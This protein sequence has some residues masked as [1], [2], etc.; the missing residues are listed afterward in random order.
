[1]ERSFAEDVKQLGYGAGQVLRG[2]GILAIT[3]ALLQSGVSYVGGYPGAPISHLLDVLADANDSLLRPLGIYYEMSG[4]EAA[5]A[6]LLGA[7]INYP[8]RGAVTWKSVVG[9]NVAS[10]ALSHVASAGV[11]GGALVVIG[12]DY[13]EGAS[14]LQ[15][16]THSSALKSSIPLIDP[17]N[18]LQHFARM[19][20]EGFALSE[21]CHEPVFFSIRIRACHMRGTLVCKDNVPPGISMR[22]PLGR[23]SFSLER[24]NLPPFTYQMEAMKF[25]ERLP[26]ARR[27]IVEHALNEH[28]RGTEPDV[29]IVMQ[30]G[31]WNT[32]VRGL[33]ELGLSDV[34]GRTP[35]P[36]LVL[37]VLHPLVPEELVAFLRGKR[38]VLVVEE[39]M[40][41]YVEREL[42]AL[43]HEARLD[44]DV[45]G[46]D[47]FSPN[48][49]YVPQL[50]IGGLRRFLTG[51][52]LA[53]V[54]AASVEERYQ[55]LVEHQARLREALPEPV[56]KRPPSFCTGCP[57]R[58]LF[59]A[60][61][62]LRG[63]EPTLGETHVAADIGCTTFS[64]QAPFNV[65]NTV[66][67]YGMGLASAGAVAPLF[68]KRVISVMGD[69][70]FWHNGLTNGVASAV[71]NKQDSVLV[72]V[73]NKYTSATGQHPNPSTGTNARREPTG[74]TIPDALRGVGVK[75]IREVDSYRIATVLRTLREALTT[76]APGLK[77]VIARGECQLERQ[78]RE[79]PLARARLAAGVSV[80]QPRFGV[81]PDVC[82][83]DH[84]CMRLNGCPS[85]TLRA[86]PDPLREDPIAH[87]DDTCV[88]CGVCGE[89]AHAAVLCPSFY[90]VRVLRNPSRWQRFLARLRHAVIGRLGAGAPAGA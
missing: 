29:G 21:A 47:V 22:S 8:M 40:P 74:M 55:R 15:E 2:E 1:V 38:R 82:T 32:T 70:G 84:S 69:G 17:R 78:R 64:T 48:G 72:I 35:V 67:G 63:T 86:N 24:I 53:G 45:H 41:N 49:E 28:R 30:G 16:R 46:K 54:A 57:E 76:R 23:P 77:V 90:E 6:A 14:I 80:V 5:A 52:G 43:A 20:E 7:S 10:D 11:V 4:S 27:F 9:T 81:D 13:G 36:M 39:G 12:E 25:G 42:K 71:Y 37:N 79:K 59:S 26:A 88:G 44:V 33:H 19:V 61:K 56:A 51:G 89:V 18:D 58:P 3:K 83:G 87:V 60:M 68:G 66:L 31:L 75:W 50:V 62:I 34:A 65:G 73:D 85:L